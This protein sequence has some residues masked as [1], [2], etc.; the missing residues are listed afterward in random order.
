MS[1]KIVSAKGTKTVEAKRVVKALAKRGTI[2]KAQIRSAVK[3]AS[4][5]HSG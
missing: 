5:K 2:S 3:I 1:C 4:K